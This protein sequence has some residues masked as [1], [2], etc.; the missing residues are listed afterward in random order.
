MKSIYQ[1]LIFLF[2]IV[3]FNGFS[4]V[5]T[6][7]D[8]VN[9]DVDNCPTVANIPDHL[10]KSLV[11]AEGMFSYSNYPYGITLDASGNLYIADG[12]NNRIQKWIPGTTEGV[13]VAGG[14]GRGPAANQFNE[15]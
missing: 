3:S 13:T 7:G 2:F 14:N 12:F 1:S 4:Q 15:P 10:K 6:D 9:D 5:D 11:F 8:G